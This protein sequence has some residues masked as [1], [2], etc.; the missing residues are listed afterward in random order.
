MAL[1]ASC[2]HSVIRYSDNYEANLPNYSERQSF[3]LYGIGQKQ[4]VDASKYCK[5]TGVERVEVEHK[6]SDVLFRL[7]TLGIYTPR[8]LEIY[9]KA[10]NNVI[11]V[12]K[13]GEQEELKQ[14]ESKADEK[15][16]EVNPKT[17]PTSNNGVAPKHDR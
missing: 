8:S 12:D 15:Y 16:N 4:D 11:L 9:C 10:G 7:L 3:W 13:K 1:L 6:F 17:L 14:I 2:S 5:N